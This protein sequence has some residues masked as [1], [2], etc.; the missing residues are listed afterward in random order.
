MTMEIIQPAHWSRP[1]GYAHGIIAEGRLLFL[2]GQVGWDENGRIVGDGLVEQIDQALKNVLCLLSE[3][4]A[5]ARD[6]V[7]MTW[8]ITDKQAYLTER[9]RIGERWR[10]RMG[11]HY[12]VM[13]VVEVSSLLE[14]GAKVE[15]EATAV[16]SLKSPGGRKQERG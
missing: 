4:G 2:S 15:I 10:A 11:R 12:P 1:S 13:S 6:V 5:E 16:I 9:K 7:R 3:A 14:E 8:Y